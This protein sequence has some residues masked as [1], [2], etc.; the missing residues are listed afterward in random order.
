MPPNLPADGGARK[1]MKLIGAANDPGAIGWTI[2]GVL[3]WIVVLLLVRA[4]D[5][6]YVKTLKGPLESLRSTLGQ[7]FRAVESLARGPRQR[8]KRSLRRVLQRVRGRIQTCRDWFAEQ[9][10]KW[11]RRVGR[12]GRASWPRIKGLLILAAGL[13]VVGLPT[14]YT[15]FTVG[16]ASTTATDEQHLGLWLFVVWGAIALFAG[17]Q[18]LTSDREVLRLL[19]TSVRREASSRARASAQRRDQSPARRRHRR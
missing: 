6:L 17:I 1:V 11:W 15:I 4:L 13:Y 16:D 5:R 2:G 8:V 9:A 3:F 7:W 14:Y 18:T 12:A 19:R 10:Q